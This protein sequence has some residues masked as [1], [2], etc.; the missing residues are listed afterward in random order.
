VPQEKIRRIIDKLCEIGD[1]LDD[2]Q[3][4]LERL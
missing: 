4:D 2:L 1:I 3:R